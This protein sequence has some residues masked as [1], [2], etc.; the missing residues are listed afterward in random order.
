V[1][2][3][4]VLADRAAVLHWPGSGTAAALNMRMPIPRLHR[5]AATETVA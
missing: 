1:V 5:L 3:E 4:C 2:V